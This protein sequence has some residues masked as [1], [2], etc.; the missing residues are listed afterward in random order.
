MAPRLRRPGYETRRLSGSRGAGAYSPDVCDQRRQELVGNKAPA[1]RSDGM[2]QQ[3]WGAHAPRPSFVGLYVRVDGSCKML[4]NLS[5]S[6]N[7][8][9]VK[10]RCGRGTNQVARTG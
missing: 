10:G 5:I 1:M 7:S 4:C 8:Q 3:S 9:T 2:R 6:T